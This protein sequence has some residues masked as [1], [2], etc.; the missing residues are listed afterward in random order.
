MFEEQGTTQH[1]GLSLWRAFLIQKCSWKRNELAMGTGSDC[2]RVSNG[3]EL[4]PHDITTVCLCTLVL[5]QNKQVRYIWL[6]IPV[7]HQNE[8]VYMAFKLR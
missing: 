5:V 7:L 4:K 8:C 6:I 1:A 3:A 2:Y